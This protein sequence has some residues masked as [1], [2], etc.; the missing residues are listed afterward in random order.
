MNFSS[1]AKNIHRVEFIVSDKIRVGISHVRN[2]DRTS[3]LS[4]FTITRM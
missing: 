3:L 2:D 1:H 4:T